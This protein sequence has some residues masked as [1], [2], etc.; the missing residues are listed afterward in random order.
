MSRGFPWG[1]N[2]TLADNTIQNC[3]RGIR[4]SPN[5]FYDGFQVVA[6]NLAI[7]N[8]TI[9]N[10]TNTEDAAP[11]IEISNGKVNVLTI[12]DNKLSRIATKKYISIPTGSTNVSNLGN[13][14][15]SLLDE[16]F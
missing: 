2:F 9:R 14:I 12:M 6:H 11:A 7:R 3:G 10:L 5:P 16:L 1:D 4:F 13:R 8:N 15:N